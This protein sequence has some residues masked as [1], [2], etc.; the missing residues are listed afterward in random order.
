MNDE[1]KLVITKTHSQMEDGLWVWN[2]LGYYYRL[3]ITGRMHNAASNISFVVLSN[4]KDLAFDEVWKASGFSSSS[5]DYF[6]PT[7]AVIVGYRSFD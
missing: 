6:K 5:A 1:E 4:R 7:D 3:E 2:G